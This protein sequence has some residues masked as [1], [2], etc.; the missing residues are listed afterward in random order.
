MLIKLKVK[1][2]ILYGTGELEIKY[3]KHPKKINFVP[4]NYIIAIDDIEKRTACANREWTIGLTSFQ[5]IF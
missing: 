2:F 1:K 3:Y 5:D 4:E